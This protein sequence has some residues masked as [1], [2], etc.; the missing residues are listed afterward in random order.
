MLHERYRYALM[1]VCCSAPN[2]INTLQNFQ[3]KFCRQATAARW[4]V[5]NSVLH[6]DLELPTISKHVKDASKRFFDMAQSHLNPLIASAATYEPPP[7]HHFRGRKTH[8]SKKHATRIVGIP[9]L[10]HDDPKAHLTGA[11]P[12]IRHPPQSFQRE[13]KIFAKSY[14]E[15]LITKHPQGSRAPSASLCCRPLPTK[16][17]K[18]SG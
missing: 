16:T 10:L 18:P 17:S 11:F 4:C 6:G 1:F 13:L 7:A 9:P 15:V 5:E 12:R 3:N 8:G 2:I 14:A